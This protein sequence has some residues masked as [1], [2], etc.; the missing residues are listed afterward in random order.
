V[1]RKEGRNGGMEGDRRQEIGITKGD[2]AV[3]LTIDEPIQQT[4]ATAYKIYNN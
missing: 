3:L 1:D 4:P 2:D